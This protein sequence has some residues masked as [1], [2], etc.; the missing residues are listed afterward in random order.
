M[1]Y[2]NDLHEYPRPALTVD[3]VVFGVDLEERDLRVLLI[4]RDHPPFKHKWALPGGYV[5]LE[6][7][8]EEAA[9]RELAE[10]TNVA[11]VYLEELA[12]FGDVDRDPR[13]R[14][15]TVAYYGLVTLR[16]YDV[17]GATDARDAAWFSVDEVEQ[18][19]FD[20]DRILALAWAR[21][22]QQVLQEPIAFALLPAAFTLTQ[23]QRLYEIILGT[24]LDKRNFRKK[25][26]SL[27]LLER[28][29]AVE[30]HV[31]HRAAWLYRF[32]QR[33]YQRKKKR[34]FRFAL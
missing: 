11:D 20:H 16:E 22:R 8:L 4:Q 3:C 32:D 9:R 6:E 34:G 7:S 30:R 1:D 25:V 5:H 19:A 2:G 28:L 21:L 14:I 26:L 12:V 33:E 23:L 15:V 31:A 18:L 17:R 29:K 10:E 13:G 24:P 27:G